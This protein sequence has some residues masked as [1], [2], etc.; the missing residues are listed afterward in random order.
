MKNRMFK[1]ALTILLG[2]L[3]MCFATSCIVDP[4]GSSNDANDTAKVTELVGKENDT[5]KVTERVTEG[6]TTEK[7]TDG[8]SEENKTN[9]SDGHTQE[10]PTEETPKAPSNGPGWTQNY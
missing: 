4:Q 7:V 3:L 6:N 5:D 2:A 10:T 1:G 9:P 8:A